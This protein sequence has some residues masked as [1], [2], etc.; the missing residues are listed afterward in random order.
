MGKGQ[1]AKEG[2]GC[3]HKGRDGG[4]AGDDHRL[5]CNRAMQLEDGDHTSSER[6]HTNHNGE[7]QSNGLDPEHGIGLFRDRNAV[8]NQV[9][10]FRIQIQANA[11]QGGSQSTKSIVSAHHLGQ[12]RHLH[13]HGTPQS[14]NGARSH[15]GRN[16]PSSVAVRVG[17][18]DPIGR[19]QGAHTSDTVQHTHLGRGHLLERS[20]TIETQT[21]L[22]HGEKHEKSTNISFR[23]AALALWAGR[24][25]S[26]AT[27]WLELYVPSTSPSNK[28]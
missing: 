6:H 12:T 7:N 25:L 10:G 23:A 13:G 8:T 17:I 2:H 1:S 3:K 9:G 21:S 24:R 4:T 5:A 18:V 19:H 15:T 16:Q 14:R 20:K 28:G 26:L 27:L 22:F 11:R